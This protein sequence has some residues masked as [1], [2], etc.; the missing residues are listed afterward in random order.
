MADKPKRRRKVQK[1]NQAEPTEPKVGIFFLVDKKLLIDP[2]PVSDGGSYGD[3]SIHERGHDAFW[4]MLRR[5]GAVPP[6]TEYDDYPRGRVAYNTKTGK[7]S[8]LL[9][10]CIL[11]N[12][13]VVNKIMS[14]LNLPTKRTEMDTDSQYRCPRCLKKES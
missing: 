2:T 8:L 7:Y 12:K 13:S 14:E 3:F 9:D 6:D 11:K 4:E 10:R 5:T 1:R